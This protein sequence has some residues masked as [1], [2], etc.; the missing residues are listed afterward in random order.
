MAPQGLFVVFTSSAGDLV[1][2][3]ANGTS[4]VFV[5]TTPSRQTGTTAPPTAS[6]SQADQPSNTTG[7]TTLQFTVTYADDVDLATTSFDDD[8][9][10]L[11]LKD[12]SVVNAD[13]QVGSV[14]SGKNAKVTY[15][16]AAPGGAVDEA[17]N[18]LYTVTIRPNSVADAN[19]NFVAA[20]ALPQIQITAVPADG[21][22]LTVTIPETIPAAVSGSRGRA[23][24]VVSN[25]GNQPVPRR[26]RMTLSL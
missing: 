2:N 21:P 22:D 6:I 13:A 1:T 25:T 7:A 5:A 18:G 15:S 10:T 16:V 26:S 17:D 19:G 3:D 23:R 12:G 20:G 8:D 14:G 4:D 24:V 9:V 11:T